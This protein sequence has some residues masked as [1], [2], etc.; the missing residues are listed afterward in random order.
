MNFVTIQIFLVVNQLI[1]LAMVA[2]GKRFGGVYCQLYEVSNQITEKFL[3][4]SHSLKAK[5]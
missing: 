4:A 5:L 1:T 2:Y 3:V